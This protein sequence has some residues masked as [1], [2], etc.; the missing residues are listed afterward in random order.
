MRVEIFDVG[1]GHCTVITSPNGRRLMLDCG[2]RWGEERFWTPSLHY[3]RQSIDLLALLNLDEDHIA[4][5][6]G[7]TADCTVPWILSNPTVGPCEFALLKKQGMGVGAKS[8]AAW[9]ARPRGI[10]TSVEPDFGPVQIR[11]Y[12]GFFVPGTKN[13]TNDL[14]L[15]VI[16]QFGAFKIVFAGDLGVAGWKRLLALPSFC[17][18]L[19]GTT[20]LVASHHG[21]NSGCCTELFD[22]FRPQLVIISDDERQ[23]DSQDT[24]DWYRARCTGAVFATNAFDR[25]YVATTRKDGSM[26]IDVEPDG[27]WRIHRV[28]VRDWP[29]KPVSVPRPSVDWLSALTPSFNP[30]SP[31]GNLLA[32]LPF[33]DPDT[34]ALARLTRDDD[35]LARAL[36]LSPI[37]ALLA[38]KR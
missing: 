38:M 4:D 7:M 30:L 26:R 17:Q 10:P 33:P 23:Y 16:A 12:Y 3:F 34:N 9:L 5:F 37:S 19:L 15:V 31:G 28:T 22:L 27:R 20:V 14:S 11:W 24:D 18:D 36:G 29:T 32:G 8:V 1:H 21:R 35:P 2:N 13:N 6:Q 25:R